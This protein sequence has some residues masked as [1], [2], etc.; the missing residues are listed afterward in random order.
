MTAD[1]DGDDKNQAIA[2]RTVDSTK[3]NKAAGLHVYRDSFERHFI[4]ETIKFYG[5]ESQNFLAS[6][7]VEEYIR[8]VSW[9]KVCF[10]FF[11]FALIFI[12]NDFNLKLMIHILAF[13]G[14]GSTF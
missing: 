14:D 1:V 5:V 12:E 6:N 10:D 13:S 7:P 2:N 3:D 4:E 8:K 9:C 11:T